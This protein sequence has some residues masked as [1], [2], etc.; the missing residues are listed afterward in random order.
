GYEGVTFLPVTITP[1]STLSPGERV[2]LAAS[3]EWL[4]C[5]DVCIPGSAD[6]LLELTVSESA[7]KA[8]S[9]WGEKINET[10]AN[11]PRPLPDDWQVTATRDG[12]SV[13]IKIQPAD[14]QT[15][16]PRALHFFSDDNI[17][18]YDQPQTV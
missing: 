15:H 7:P 9:D 14:G 3:A 10:V 17:V 18:A 1:P 16:M 8:D 5:S 13:S 2:T 4:M 12:Q 11:L 6:V